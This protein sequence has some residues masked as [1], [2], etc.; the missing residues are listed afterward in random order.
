MLFLA[1]DGR[2]ALAPV[3]REGSAGMLQHFRKIDGLAR[4]HRWRQIDQPLWICSKSAHHFERCRCIFLANRHVA[5]Q[6]GRDGAL[7]KNI[8]EV[9][10]I[11]VALL[12]A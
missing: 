12:R 1:H 7:S 2:N 6:S 9:E 3:I 4:C 5:I 11:V 10:R 8:S